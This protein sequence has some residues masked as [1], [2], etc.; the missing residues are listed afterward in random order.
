MSAL[1]F[2]GANTINID[3][4]NRNSLTQRQSPPHVIVGPR[5]EVNEVLG[6]L[7][8]RGFGGDILGQW[9][10]G[11]YVIP[12]RHR[13]AH[14]EIIDG[15]RVPMGWV[16]YE[17]LCRDPVVMERHGLSLSESLA[18]FKKHTRLL[19]LRDKGN[20]VHGAID[21]D[22]KTWHHPEVYRRKALP[23]TAGHALSPADLARELAGP[24]AA[25]Q[26]GPN[27]DDLRAQAK[28]AGFKNTSRM[29]LEKLQEMLGQ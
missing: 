23:A 29:G 16:N 12:Q 11:T 5:G 4:P 17:D 27:I 28:A 19:E 15:E 13:F 18:Y 9:R 8:S 24:E 14:F 3:D 20:E 25:P 1:S 7:D 22:A 2:V 6:E 21:W 26:D 10:E